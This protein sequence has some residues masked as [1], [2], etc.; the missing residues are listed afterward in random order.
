MAKWD[1]RLAL[2]LI[3]VLR[4]VADIPDDDVKSESVGIRLKQ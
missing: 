3:K 2:P 1:D 4:L